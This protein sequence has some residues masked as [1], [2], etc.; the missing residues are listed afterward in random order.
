MISIIGDV[1]CTI[2][3]AVYIISVAD[4]TADVADYKTGQVLESHP[5]V[6]AEVSGRWKETMGK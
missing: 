5:T 3:V 6:C 1:G 2:S 4:C